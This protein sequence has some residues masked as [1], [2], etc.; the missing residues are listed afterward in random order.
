MIKNKKTLEK[1]GLKEESKNAINNK[2]HHDLV[3]ALSGYKEQLGE[4]K[5]EKKIKKITK[6]FAKGLKKIESK[7]PIT[8]TIKKKNNLKKKLV[9]KQ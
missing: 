7:E 4:K 8:S 1:K 2:I 3:T 9:V 6:L 5:L